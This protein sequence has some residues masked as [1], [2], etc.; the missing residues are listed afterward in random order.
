MIDKLLS[1]SDN[2]ISN[3]LIDYFG[4]QRICQICNDNGYSS[5]EFQ[6][7]IGEQVAD[8]DNYISAADTAE[9]LAELYNYGNLIDKTYLRN[10]FIIA[11]SIR[12][13]GLGKYLPSDIK[14]LNHNAFT[15]STYNEVC[16]IPDIQN[17]YILAFLSNDGEYEVSKIT[18]AKVS[19]Y[20]FGEFYERFN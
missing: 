17:P 6:R 7:H 13:D 4:M 10:R 16:I 20:V 2:N 12:Y 8:R 18:A 19:E 9:M 11:D 1:Y 3:T 14:F 15:D 5:V